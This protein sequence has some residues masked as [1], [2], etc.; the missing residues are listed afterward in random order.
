MGMYASILARS[1]VPTTHVPTHKHTLTHTYTPD[2]FVNAVAERLVAARLAPYL[3]DVL[4]VLDFNGYL[5][6]TP[7]GP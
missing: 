3:A 2:V 5:E 7:Y 4:L 6:A 1:S